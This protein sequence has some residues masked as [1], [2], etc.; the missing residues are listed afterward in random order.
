MGATRAVLS[1]GTPKPLVLLTSSAHPGGCG[2]ALGGGCYTLL[3][4]GS[5]MARFSEGNLT[6]EKMTQKLDQLLLPQALAAARPKMPAVCG[7]QQ[8][9]ACGTLV[10]T[11]EPWAFAGMPWAPSTG[12]SAIAHGPQLGGLVSTDAPGTFQRGERI[13]SWSAV[14]NCPLH[15]SWDICGPGLPGPLSFPEHA[16]RGCAEMPYLFVV[17]FPQGKA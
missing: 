17:F 13:W 12:F 6:K 9:T 7:G 3:V 1:S 8:D 16:G 10:Q 14:L 5:G 11:Q 2:T 15:S 4:T